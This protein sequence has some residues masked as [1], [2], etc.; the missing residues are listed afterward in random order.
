MGEALAQIPTDYAPTSASAVTALAW[1]P[2]VDG[3]PQASNPVICEPSDSHAVPR[4]LP[5]RITAAIDA[6][7]NNR[8]A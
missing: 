2:T 5:W 3:L 8:I 4:I 7:A 1:L 6:G